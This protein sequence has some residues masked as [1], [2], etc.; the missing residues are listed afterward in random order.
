MITII[1][2][3]PEA[4]TA[5][6]DISGGSLQFRFIIENVHIVTVHNTN[7]CHRPQRAHPVRLSVCKSERQQSVVIDGSGLKAPDPLAEDPSSF[8]S[9]HIRI[10]L[11]I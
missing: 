9:T 11:Y 5:E 7:D 1:E 2:N 3:Y 10:G 6:M 8:P 4:A